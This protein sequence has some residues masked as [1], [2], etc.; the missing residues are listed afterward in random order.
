MDA[1]TAVANVESLLRLPHARTGGETDRF[2][3]AWR[4]TTMDA[5][6]RGN[7]VPDSHL[8]ALM[9]EYGIR[10]IYSRDRG[11]RRFRGIEVLDPLEPPS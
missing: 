7:A 8:V 9:H 6:P 11:L 3:E 5:L 2:W 10:S 1:A 4:A